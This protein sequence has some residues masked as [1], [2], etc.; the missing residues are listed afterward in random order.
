[1]FRAMFSAHHHEL[2]TVHT[3][4]GTAAATASGS[5]SKPGMYQMLCVQS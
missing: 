2:K 5:S 3:A 4:S 1:M